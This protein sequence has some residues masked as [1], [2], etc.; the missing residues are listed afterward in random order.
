MTT[1]VYYS[2]TDAGAP[3]LNNAAGSLINLL[4]AV[5][6]NGYGTKAVTSISVSSGV[7]TV[8]CS[9]HG[10][11]NSSVQE[12]AGATPALLNGRKLITVTGANGFTFAAPGVPDGSASGTS[13][14]KRPGLG[15]AKEYSSGSTKAVY[16]R[17]DPAATAMRLRVADSAA[18]TWDTTRHAEV[19]MYESMSDVDTGVSPAPTAHGQ[20]WPKGLNNATAARWFAVGDSRTIYLFLDSDYSGS[21]WIYTSSLTP[22]V[23]G[24]VA[25]YRASDAYACVL[26]GPY[27]HAAQVAGICTSFTSGD[28][29]SVNGSVYVARRA[30][31]L[32]GITSFAAIGRRPGA[33][34]SALMP[35]YPSPVDN[36]AVFGFPLLLAEGNAAFNNPARGEL[37]GLAEPLFDCTTVAALTV[38]D[39]VLGSDRKWLIAPG[40][41]QSG[42]RAFVMI[43]ITGPW[44]A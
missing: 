6:V 19:T 11:T 22:C 14:A 10:F 40:N 29:P 25:S 26:S 39:D 37:R 35:K 5:L 17:T 7:A 13:T 16:K 41:Y 44:Q 23:F 42:D 15:W 30:S 9:A 1:V 2:S 32:A 27:T 34:G 21:Q 8:V 31:G 43:D 28:G 38:F 3:T 24:D 36:G 20:T 4:D 12:I 18:G 33:M